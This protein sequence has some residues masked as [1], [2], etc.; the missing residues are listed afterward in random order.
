MLTESLGLIERPVRFRLALLGLAALAISAL[1]AVGVLLVIPLVEVMNGS[2]VEIPLLGSPG[3]ALIMTSVVG[4]FIAKSVIMAALRW[5]ILGVTQGAYSRA[6]TSLFE[7]LLRA[8]LSFHDSRNGADSV[9]L[10]MISV[11]NFFEQGV[12]GTANLL[13]E[14]ASVL[15]LCTLLLVQAPLAGTVALAYLAL[16]MGLYS[17]IVHRRTSSHAHQTEQLTG[18]SVQ[19]VQEAL[20]ALAEL[21]VRG[22]A[23]YVVKPF[24]ETMSSL[25]AARRRVVYATEL[26]RYYL[27]VVFFGAIGAVAAVVLVSEPSQAAMSTLAVFAVVGFRTLLSLARVLAAINR[28]RVG[29]VA[30]NLVSSEIDAIQSAIQD[31]NETDDSPLLPGAASVD[32]AGLDFRYTPDGPKVLDQ[33]E[34][35]LPAGSRTGIVGGSGSGKSTLLELICGL[36][37]ATHGSVRVDVAGEPTGRPRIGYVPQAVFTIDSTIRENV[38]LGRVVEDEAIWNALEKACIADFVKL[39]PAGLESAVGEAGTLL[40]GGQRQRLG[41]ARAYLVEPGLLI[42]DEA[43]SALD[44]ETEAQVLAQLADSR[45][46]VTI[47]IVTHRP[48]TLAFCDAAYKIEKSQLVSLPI[49]PTDREFIDAS[50][51]ELRV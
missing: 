26:S 21:R 37:V 44:V 9:R 46:D 20:G 19:H 13:A 10:V 16:S 42:L 3:P 34:V 50:Q 51:A 15:V 6:T 5:W 40:S 2:D 18:R 33:V 47:I 48:S 43:T 31:R 23:D 12:V 22:T 45:T 27:E 41:L 36:R 30:L 25:A 11:R 35:S 17:R 38:T 7:R 8:P 14:S 24:G 4:L 1:D 29:R 28:I 49:G 32:L 39:L